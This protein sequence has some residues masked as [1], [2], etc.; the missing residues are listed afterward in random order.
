MTANYAISVD[1]KKLMLH[2]ALR[3][4]AVDPMFKSKVSGSIGFTGM[5]LV[6]IINQ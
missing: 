2:H 3:L 5:V 1:S 4:Y 6:Q